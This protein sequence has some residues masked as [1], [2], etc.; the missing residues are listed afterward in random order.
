MN[1]Y[2]IHLMETAGL[3]PLP[4]ITQTVPKIIKDSST[5]LEYSP[6]V[7]TTER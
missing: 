4:H 3:E 6:T 1:S 7:L 5:Y 2:E